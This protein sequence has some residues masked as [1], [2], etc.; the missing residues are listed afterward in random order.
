MLGYIWTFWIGVVLFVVSLLVVLGL[1]VS[2]VN[3]VSRMKYPT[4]R[5]R[6]QLEQQQYEQLMSAG[7]PT[8]T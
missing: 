3:K 7:D 2:Y 8:S 5:Q 1:V 4:R 6:A